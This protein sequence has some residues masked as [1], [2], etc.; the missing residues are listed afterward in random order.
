MQ[1]TQGCSSKQVKSEEI[2]H[3]RQRLATSEVCLS[4]SEN[5]LSTSEEQIHQINSRFQAFIGAVLHYLPPLVA[6]SA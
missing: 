4:T 3:L 1:L 6:A 5:R 2:D